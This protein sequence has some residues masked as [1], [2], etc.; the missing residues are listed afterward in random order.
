MRL[1]A[2]VLLL[3]L[4]MRLQGKKGPYFPGY[5]SRHESADFIVRLNG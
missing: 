3:Q 2:A 5:N 4:K 1:A